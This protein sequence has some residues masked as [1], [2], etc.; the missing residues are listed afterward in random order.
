MGFDVLS[1]A[2]GLQA[3]KASGG[4]SSEKVLLAEQTFEGFAYASNYDAYLYNLIPSPYVLT[5]GETYFIKWNGTVYECVAQDLSAMMEG[6]VAVGNLSPLGLSGDNEPFIISYAA[7]S[8]GSGFLAFDTETSHRVKI[9]QET[10]SSKTVELDFSDGDM[11]ISAGEGKAFSKVDIPKPETL[12]PENIAKDVSIAGIVGTLSAG[13]SSDSSFKSD[14]FDVTAGQMTIE[15][16]GNAIPD[17]IIVAINDSPDNGNVFF[18]F[19]CSNA[20][21]SKIGGGYVNE[22]SVI[23]NGVA[24]SATSDSGIEGSGSNYY[25]RYGGVRNVTATTFEIG[26]SKYTY[27]QLKSGSRYSWYAFYGLV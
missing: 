5:V 12:I 25:A 23:N 26:N 11:E 9:Y 3:G 22:V 2:I 13:G 1:Y 19:G 14:T 7:S 15:H 8:N 16:G 10:I 6:T 27:G 18:S 17:L 24:V 20:M 4:G 21:L